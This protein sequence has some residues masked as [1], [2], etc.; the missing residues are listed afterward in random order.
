MSVL[1]L[2]I[3]CYWVW[4][5]IHHL[6][7]FVLFLSFLILF[8]TFLLPHQRFLL[9]NHTNSA[10]STTEQGMSPAGNQSG[11]LGLVTCVGLGMSGNVLCQQ[12][13]QPCPTTVL[14][15][16]AASPVAVLQ[17]KGESLGPEGGERGRFKHI[18]QLGYQVEVMLREHD[19]SL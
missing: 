19:C 18:P 3:A 5:L 6:S 1:G 13:H 10:I 9:S 2:R 15:I 17:M 4:L 11:G 7:F 14:I 12:Q 8:V 16:Q